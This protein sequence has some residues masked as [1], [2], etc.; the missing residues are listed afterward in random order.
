M[1]LINQAVFTC[2]LIY[3]IEFSRETLPGRFLINKAV[4]FAEFLIILLKKFVTIK[5]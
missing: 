1:K 5:F 2:F 4:E 3:F